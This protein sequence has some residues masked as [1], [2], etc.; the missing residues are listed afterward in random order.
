MD[1]RRRSVF[2]A[3]PIVAC[4]LAAPSL[5]LA[6]AQATTGVI[7]GTVTDSTGHPL[8]DAHVSLRHLSTNAE[9]TLTTNASGVYIATL[10]RVGIYDVAARAVGYQEDR[11]DSVEVRLGE[12]VEINFA[13]AP[14]V[15]QLQELTV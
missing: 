10:L 12:T 13:L 15:V 2:C 11:R 4:L 9:R 7:R 8:A 3:L 6:Q 5:A 1:S 14:Q